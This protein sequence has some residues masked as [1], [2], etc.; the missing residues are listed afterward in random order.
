MILRMEGSPTSDGRKTTLEQSFAKTFG[1][2]AHSAVY[3]H[4]GHHAFRSPVCPYE[5]RE[6]VPPVNQF[7]FAILELLEYECSHPL[8]RCYTSV[9]EADL[10]R[11]LT[12]EVDDTLRARISGLPSRGTPGR[13]NGQFSFLY[14]DGGCDSKQINIG[15]HEVAFDCSL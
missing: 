2:S 15:D 5:R 1:H 11:F 3:A 10:W 13:D 7:L 4:L 9:S 12:G 6:N 14:A 8:E